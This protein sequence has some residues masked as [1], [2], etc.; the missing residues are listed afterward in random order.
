MAKAWRR[1]G[2]LGAALACRFGV[3]DVQIALEPPDLAYTFSFGGSVEPDFWIIRL[4]KLVLGEWELE[5][6]TTLPDEERSGFLN[7]PGS[8]TFR[9]G[10]RGEGDPEACEVFSDPLVL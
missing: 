8:G 7:D 1:S 4:Y 3:F 9:A 10:V 2:G 6:A 5:D